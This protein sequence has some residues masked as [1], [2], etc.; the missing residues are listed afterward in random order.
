MMELNELAKKLIEIKFRLDEFWEENFGK[1]HKFKRLSKLLEELQREFGIE[2]YWA[3]K[4]IRQAFNIRWV[5]CGWRRTRHG[6]LQYCLPHYGGY[7]IAVV[8]P[9][10]RARDVLSLL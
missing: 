5:F 2:M 10:I 1:P 6:G 9:K 4:G 3:K 7:V 8:F